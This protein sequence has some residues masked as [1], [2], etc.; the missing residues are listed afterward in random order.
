MSVKTPY[1]SNEA[2]SQR[3]DDLRHPRFLRIMGLASDYSAGW[4][5]AIVAVCVLVQPVDSPS[6][7]ALCA[8]LI[9]Q[10][11]F[12]HLL[13]VLAPCR[14]E[15]RIRGKQLIELQLVLSPFQHHVLEHLF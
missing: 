10:V 13:D 15:R 1:L 2:V 8:G 3:F 11:L 12:E 4:V 7:F 9:V 6:S 14:F 5:E